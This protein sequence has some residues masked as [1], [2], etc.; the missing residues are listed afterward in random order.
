MLRAA[1]TL[2]LV[3]T[4]IGWSCKERTKPDKEQPAPVV[5]TEDAAALVRAIDA[6]V[7]SPAPAAYFIEDGQL[8][9]RV[10]GKTS[11][12]VSTDGEICFADKRASAVWIGSKTGLY[13]F[14]LATV[15]LTAV[16]EAPG[17]E[18]FE[19]RFGDGEGKLGNANSSEHDVA[20]VVMVTPLPDLRAE[21]ICEGAREQECYATSES[22]DPEQWALRP[23]VAALKKR[24]DAMALSSSDTLAML[25]KRRR[26]APPPVNEPAGLSTDEPLA[27]IPCGYIG[28]D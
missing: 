14:D 26:A 12:L 21:V 23:S 17:I 19:F 24:Y 4:G 16:V 5:E 28:E 27:G 10:E 18:V 13:V 9:R 2:L 8:W 25:A 1:C 11:V 20:L 6:T 15:A 3:L 7:L 22:D